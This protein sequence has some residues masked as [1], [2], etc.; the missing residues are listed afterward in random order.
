MNNAILF[1]DDYMLLEY[2]G[3]RKRFF[4]GKKMF[5]IPIQKPH[6]IGGQII[7]EPDTGIYR[8]WRRVIDTKRDLPVELRIYESK[9]LMD[10]TELPG[11]GPID[12]SDPAVGFI[13]RDIFEPDPSMRYKSAYI[14]RNPDNATGYGYISVSPDGLIWSEK[15]KHQFCDYVSDSVNSAFYNPVFQ[16]HQITL[17]GGFIDRRIFCVNSKD[18]LIWTKPR[19][20]MMPCPTDE[21]CTEY[22]GMSVFPQE[23]YF[24]GL[25]QKFYPP[26]PSYGNRN[27]KSAG[28]TDTFL[29]YSYDGNCWNLVSPCPVVERPL[30]P[31]HGCS[32][33]YL[34]SLNPSPDGSEWILSG[35]IRRV[36]HSCSVPPEPAHQEACAATGLYKIRKEG[37]I[38]LESNS[39]G[40]EMTFRRIILNGDDLFFNLCAPLG[41]ARFQIRDAGGVIPGFA[42]EDCIPFICNDQTR[43]RPQWQARDIRE[44]RG[45]NITIQVRMYMALFFSITGDFF[46]HT[47]YQPMINLGD[48]ARPHNLE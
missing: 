23:G 12:P 2:A 8:N 42:Y 3:V 29:T 11:Y 14:V 47:G 28:V 1:F 19:C 44:L 6:E 37:F 41:W 20:L 26:V 13:N 35:D 32:G 40:S 38:G 24:L 16:E 27:G 5:E 15:Y 22:Y 33:I 21:P 46:N 10:W 7:Y 31:E 43:Y 39:E 4:S 36:D 48:T 30:P 9:N 17:R 45:K 25:L 34:Y 18:Q